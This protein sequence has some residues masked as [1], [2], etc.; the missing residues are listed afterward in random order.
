M[1]SEDEFIEELEAIA[2]D[3]SPGEHL[4]SPASPDGIFPVNGSPL[5]IIPSSP[6]FLPSLDCDNNSDE[7]GRDDEDD[8]DIDEGILYLRLMALKSMSAE[9]DAETADEKHEREMHQLLD[10]ANQAV[11]EHVPGR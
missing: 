3:A 8:D 1:F 2:C 6:S 10:E 11:L 7:H 9:T 4:E 5:K